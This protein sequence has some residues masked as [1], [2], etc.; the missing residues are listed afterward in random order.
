MGLTHEMNF[1]SALLL[2]IIFIPLAGL[3]ETTNIFAIPSGCQVSAQTKFPK[4]FAQN[5][6]LFLVGPI[7]ISK[8]PYTIYNFIIEE[9]FSSLMFCGNQIKKKLS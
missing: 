5:F 8:P 4:Q 7:S 1:S 2:F 3:R 6:T 9:H